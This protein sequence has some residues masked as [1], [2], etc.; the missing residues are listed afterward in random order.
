MQCKPCSLS[1]GDQFAG[2]AFVVRVSFGISSIS[3]YGFSSQ[4]LIVKVAVA[5]VLMSV[6]AYVRTSSRNFFPCG[7]GGW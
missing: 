7:G 2:T 5:C 6:C 3:S 4:L 1:F